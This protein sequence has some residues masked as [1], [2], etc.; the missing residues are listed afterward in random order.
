MDTHD[1][2]RRVPALTMRTA[3]F[4][5]L[6]AAPPAMAAHLELQL[7]GV[8]GPFKNAA[9]AAAGMADYSTRD[10]TAAQAHRLFDRA[11][12]QIAAA[13]EP[14]GFYKAKAQGELKETPNGFLAVIHADLGEPMTVS[15]FDVQ[16]P[17]P[18]RDEKIVRKA[19]ATF[20]PKKGDRLDHAN[21]EKS[22]AAVQAALLSSGYLDA[23][24]T[25]RAVE[26]SRTDNRASIHLAWEVGK[27][28]R[29][30]AT[31]FEGGQFYDGFLNRY[32]PWH[33]GDFYSQ[34]DLL[35]L[36]QQLIDADYFAVVEVQPQPEKAHDGVVPI[37]VTLGPAKRNVYTAGIFLDT[38][39]GFG[40]R[41]GMQR[42]W[43]N[44][45]G[46]KLKVDVQLAQKLR[47]ASVVY[48]I[49]LPGPNNR[50]YNF[51]ANYLNENTD[52][53]V[54]HTQ[55]LVAN[56][57]RQW[58]G[59]TRTLGLHLLTGTFDIL[60]PNGNQALEE[61]GTTTL[62]YPEMVLEKKKADD[63]LFVRDGYSLTLAARGAPGVVSS[64]EFAQVRAD[65]KWI[66]GIARNQ[67]IILRASAGATQVGDFDKLP[68]EL[69]FFAG[70]DRS[71]RGY[72]YQTIGPENATGLIIGGQDLLVGSAEYEY[73]FTHDWGIAVFTDAGDAFT[74]FGN[75]KT[76]VGSGLGVRWR[77]PV[78]MVRV[79]LGTPI[80]D[81]DGRTGVQLH[82]TIGPD[83]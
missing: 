70:G 63:P 59:F 20:T 74:G 29:Y 28:Y 79:D 39:I 2:P 56:E 34:D 44:D 37:L 80:H 21:Y 77:S 60:D 62:L 53:T 13:L 50:A 45:K 22:K 66:K 73:Y 16:L 69:R 11:P 1:L 7:D 17:D 10:I 42:R 61:H 25:T 30:G 68:P 78:G 64:T 32:I 75:Y 48:T 27:R 33:E 6:C 51:G 38:D 26:V 82:L 18:A 67:R 47:T 14:Y 83:L 55:S 58:L 19:M 31:T 23:K 72:S 65:Y 41:G 46:H 57:T 12:T 4:A 71:I 49:P 5:L 40:I 8:E 76:R 15:T 35:Q 24:L 9:V 3:L 54:S 36:Q 43:L 52:T 81:P